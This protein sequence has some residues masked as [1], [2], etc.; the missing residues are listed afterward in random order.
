MAINTPA[1]DLVRATLRSLNDPT[2]PVPDGT[3]GDAER[4]FI[5]IENDVE[6]LIAELN[7]NREAEKQLR[8]ALEEP[9]Q[10]NFQRR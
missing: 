1:F 10:A 4:A 8:E 3:F 2:A 9:G 7:G 5:E 6:K